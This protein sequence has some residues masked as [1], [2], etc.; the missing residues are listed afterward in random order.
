MENEDLFLSTF[1]Q[2]IK[3]TYNQNWHVEITNSR[4]AI[5][6]RT[7][8]FDIKPQLYLSCITTL[9]YRVAL[10]RFRVRSN[11]LRVETGSWGRDNCNHA[12][13]GGR[14]PYFTCMSQL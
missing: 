14:M 12:C 10:T 7:F 6:Y 5:T 4:K 2:R 8:V 11:Y 1:K 3:D 13:P 9:Q